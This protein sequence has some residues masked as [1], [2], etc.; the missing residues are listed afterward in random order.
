MARKHI[1]E[2]SIFLS[3][4]DSFL[5]LAIRAFTRSDGEEPTR[6]NHTGGFIESGP[7]D[8][9][10]V[11]EALRRIVIHSFWDKYADS[12]ADV[13]V[14]EPIGATEVQVAVVS[15]RYRSMEGTVYGYGKI[16]AQAIDHLLFKD[17]YR[18][19]RWFGYERMPICSFLVGYAWQPYRSFGV[20]LNALTPDDIHDHCK[21]HPEEW[22]QV[23]DLE[24]I[25]DWPEEE[26]E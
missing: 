3:R 10:K 1:K 11:A 20:P 12:G 4:A 13:I 17:K 8:K 7:A 26:A 2:G 22:R 5:G 9:I 15:E 6:V 14:Y 18:V 19:R 16:L 24:P 25:K 23:T 21:A